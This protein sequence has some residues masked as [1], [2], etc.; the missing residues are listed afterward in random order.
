M[1]SGQ[2]AQRRPR[3]RP[4]VRIVKPS[5]LDPCLRGDPWVERCYVPNCLVVHLNNQ[6][7]SLL[8][9]TPLDQAALNETLFRIRR[10]FPRQ[11][12]CSAV[13]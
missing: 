5:L 10:R 3:H 9:G 13:A 7:V 2:E 6:P 4:K 1:M 12:W 8:A 11:A